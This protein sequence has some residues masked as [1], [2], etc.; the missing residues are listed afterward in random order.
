MNFGVAG[1]RVDI[2]RETAYVLDESTVAASMSLTRQ[3]ERES[4]MQ[5]NIEGGTANTGT[6]IITGTVDGSSGATETLTF[7]EAGF[8]I[9]TKRFTAVSGLVTTGL[10]DEAAVPTI[11]IEAVGVGGS[12]NNASYK[13]QTGYPC[14]LDHGY[15]RWAGDKQGSTELETVQMFLPYNPVWTPR[16]GDVFIDIFTAEQFVADGVSVWQSSQYAAGM[17][18]QVKAF[19]RQGTV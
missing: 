4:I 17:F 6:V 15:T 7:T 11:G 9:T 3:P 12:R 19:R 10:A 2:Y 16:E 1:R 14:H 18:Y 5:V 13:I 8:Q